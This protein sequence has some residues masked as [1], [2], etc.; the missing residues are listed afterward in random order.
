MLI[1]ESVKFIIKLVDIGF[2]ID[3]FIKKTNFARVQKFFKSRSFCLKIF[4]KNYYRL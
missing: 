2:G 1:D 3:L 4:F